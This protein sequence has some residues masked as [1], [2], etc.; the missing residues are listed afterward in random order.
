MENRLA[1]IIL[2]YGKTDLTSRLH[3]QLLESDPGF[4]D[5]FIVDNHAPIPYPDARVR[6]PENRYWA[7]AL[8]YATEH[9]H[10]EGFTHLWFINNDIFF[11]NK[12]PI[13]SSAWQRLQRL[14][15]T[16]GKIGV[17][18]PAALSN[19]YHPQM[20][21]DISQ[22]YR[23]ATYVDGIAP[24]LNLE[25]VQD[26]GGVKCEGNEYGYGVDVA[27]SMA[28]HNANWPVVIDHQVC[29]QHAYH[30]TAKTISGFLK[31][32]GQAEDIYMRRLLGPNWRDIVDHE[33]TLFSDYTRM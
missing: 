1:V 18:S 11:T 13:I 17:Y 5:L 19:P 23:L 22:Q 33:K 3:N 29:L 20:A 4:E 14:E 12:P 24:L 6:L 9:F 25:C 2:H 16:L 21:Q 32:A 28:L 8:K 27:L 7:G 30:S 31:K 15:K 26:V 10:A